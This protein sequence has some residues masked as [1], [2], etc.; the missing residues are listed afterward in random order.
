MT[1]RKTLLL[2]EKRRA[3]QLVDLVGGKE[4]L[5]GRARMHALDGGCLLAETR[6]VLQ[7]TAN[8]VH[9]LGP[10]SAARHLLPFVL[11]NGTEALRKHREHRC[12]V[13]HLALTPF[14]G[15]G[16]KVFDLSH[17]ALAARAFASCGV[18]RPETITR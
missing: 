11:L 16:Y 18:Y 2:I 7:K 1:R 9:E 17:P 14:L 3:E 6:V 13:H 10:G 4:F 5:H 8:A 12:V 15:R